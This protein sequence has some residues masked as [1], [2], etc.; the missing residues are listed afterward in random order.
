MVM[1]IHLCEYTKKYQVVNFKRVNFV[2]NCN[3]TF[4]KE[5]C[6]VI[7]VVICTLHNRK[8]MFRDNKLF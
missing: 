5:L 3:S 6:E 2:V 1:V 8:L 7:T 4:K